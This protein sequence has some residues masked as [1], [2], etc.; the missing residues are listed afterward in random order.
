VAQ[1]VPPTGMRRCWAIGRSH[2]SFSRLAARERFG[3]VAL[4]RPKRNPG[5]EPIGAKR[6]PSNF[7]AMPVRA[8]WALAHR[9]GR[10][11]PRR[12]AA[13]AATDRYSGASR[14]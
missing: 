7:G 10:L 5:A 12:R 8:R 9:P 2:S 4:A 3:D 11:R 13:V 14:C 6:A 1:L